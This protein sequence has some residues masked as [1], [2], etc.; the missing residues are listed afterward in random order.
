MIG[1]WMGQ[2]IVEGIQGFSKMGSQSVG[3]TRIRVVSGLHE[4]PVQA[5]PSKGSDG[6]IHGEGGAVALERF[7]VGVRQLRGT[8]IDGAGT[9]TPKIEAASVVKAEVLKFGEKGVG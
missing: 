2:W 7:F 8:L 6:A 1:E 9:V 3:I 4:N 5:L